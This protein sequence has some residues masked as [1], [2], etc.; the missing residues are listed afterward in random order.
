MSSKFIEFLVDTNVYPLEAIYGASYVFVDKVYVFLSSESENMV[1]VKLRPKK[2]EEQKRINEY[3]G[4]F[5]NELL[6][7][8]LRL[9]VSSENRKVRDFIV[10][11]ALVS[12]SGYSQDDV[13]NNNSD[14]EEDFSYEEDPLG[15]AVP[16]EEKYGPNKKNGGKDKKD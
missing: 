5:F 9:K 6:N 16:W 8:S 15:I 13:I 4:E 10:G 14:K 1:K 3:K 2:E 12:A 7:Y 11:Q